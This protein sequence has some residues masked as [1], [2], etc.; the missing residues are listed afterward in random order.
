MILRPNQPGT[1]T[2]TD[3]ALEESLAN[4]REALDGMKFG[5]IVLTVHEGR[6]M[7]IDI[8]QKQRFNPKK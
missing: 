7:Q 3:L 4:V 8:T 6:V 5:Q 1:E 2:E